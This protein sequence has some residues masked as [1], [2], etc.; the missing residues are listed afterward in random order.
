MKLLLDTHVFLWIIDDGPLSSRA[1]QS[2]MDEEN[3]IYVSA[4]SYWEISIKVSNGRLKLVENWMEV[5]DREVVANGIRWLPI[6]KEHCGRIVEL[7]MIHR[8]PF[9]RLLIAQSRFEEMTLLTADDTI[10]KYD[11]PTIW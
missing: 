8:D 2:F 5:F 6:K 3:E 9:D 7:P 10:Q 4:A 1:R 11:V